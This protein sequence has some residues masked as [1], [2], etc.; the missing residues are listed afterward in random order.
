MSVERAVDRNLG[1]VLAVAVELPGKAL[2]D[3]DVC[4]RPMAQSH[5]SAPHS[6][7]NR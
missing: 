2:Q 6:L 7:R 3:W 4:E 5:S 1:S